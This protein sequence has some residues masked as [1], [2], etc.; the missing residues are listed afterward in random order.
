MGDLCGATGGVLFG[1]GIESVF[2]AADVLDRFVAGPLG[3]VGSAGDDEGD[4][5]VLAWRRS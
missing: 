5:P 3:G 4:E 2:H 1:R